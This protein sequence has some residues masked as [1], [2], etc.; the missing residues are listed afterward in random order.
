MV[1]SPQVQK[2]TQ[3][4]T[5]DAPTLGAVNTLSA[6]YKIKRTIGPYESEEM[7]VTFWGQPEVGIT[8]AE[9]AAGLV[10]LAQ[11]VISRNAINPPDFPALNREVWKRIV[12]PVMG[13]AEYQQSMQG[14][15]IEGTERLLKVVLQGGQVDVTEQEG[16]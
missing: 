14:A 1:A 12:G 5:E 11:L 2:E 8:P 10:Q 6:T 7:A 15:L 16:Q 9:F 4:A 13:H 3:Q